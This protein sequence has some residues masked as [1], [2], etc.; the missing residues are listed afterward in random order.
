MLMTSPKG[1]TLINLEARRTRMSGP[2]VH[3][4]KIYGPECSPED[5]NITPGGCYVG[6]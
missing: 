4:S 3:S 2:E 6:K 5:I 1:L